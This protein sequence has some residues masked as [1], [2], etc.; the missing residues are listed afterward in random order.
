MA[1]LL[2]ETLFEIQS[3]APAPSKDF[4]HLV[5]TKNEV[6]LR[7]WKISARVEHR[8]ILP[9]EVKK[10][11]DEFL[12]ET[13]MHRPLE[14][15]FGKGT[16]E[17]ILN[18]CRG[19]FDFIVRIPDSLKV[20][21]LSF[22]DTEDIKQLS[23]TCKA[24]QQQLQ[25]PA[26]TGGRTVSICK[27]A[28][29]DVRIRQRSVIEFLHAEGE[30]PIRIHERLKN[31]YGDATVDVSTVRR[32]VRRCNTAE[33]PSPLADKMRS[34]RPVTAVT[35]SNIQRVDDIICGDHRVTADELCGIICFSKGSV[36]KIIG[37]LGYRKVWD[38][39]N[40]FYHAGIHALVK[41][42]TKTVE[43]DGDYIEK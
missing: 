39:E 43:M 41:R 32:W 23:E 34:G 27:M 20:R 11:H 19:Q 31:V 1:S 10:T 37:Q 42:W 25:L 30:T 17:Y 33:G 3:Q 9:R 35:P 28:D 7:S 8:K 38:T 5:I 6:T 24:F 36:M 2:Q 4:H 40:A 26:P 14:K 16:M 15:I 12:N 22:L 18:L 29:I 13:M 21:I